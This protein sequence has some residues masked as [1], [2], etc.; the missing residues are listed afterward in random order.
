MKV[1]NTKCVDEY[2]ATGPPIN[3]ADDDD[4]VHLGT[5]PLNNDADGY[6]D[7]GDGDDDDAD[8]NENIG[9]GPPE[10]PQDCQVNVTST[11]PSRSLQ[12]KCR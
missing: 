1:D 9:T 8:V 3:D 10:P 2:I 6:D 11:P 5:G 4:N 7:N 12:L